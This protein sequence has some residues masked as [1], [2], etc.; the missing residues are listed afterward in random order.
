MSVLLF[1]T[2]IVRIGLASFSYYQ[3]IPHL[4]I[5]LASLLVTILAG[6]VV[7]KRFVRE[8]FLIPWYLFPLL[9]FIAYGFIQL[10]FRIDR[11]GIVDLLSY[12]SFVVLFL[13]FDKIK[14]EKKY[15]RVF[16]FIFFAL[17]VVQ[18]VAEL[19]AKNFDVFSENIARE[20]IGSI[21]SHANAASLVIAW[22]IILLL[23]KRGTAHL[24][25]RIALFLLLIILGTRSIIL[26]LVLLYSGYILSKRRKFSASP[27]I[28]CFLLLVLLFGMLLYQAHVVRYTQGDARMASLN[29]LKWRINHWGYYLA[30]LNSPAEILFGKGPGAHYPVPLP[31]YDQYREVHNDFLMQLFDFGLIGLLLF[32]FSELMIFRYFLKG[33]SQESK[34]IIY[35]IFFSK[36]FFLFFDNYATHFVENFIYIVILTQMRYFNDEELANSI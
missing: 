32:L 16:L 11:M 12:G 25:L 17:L 6:C 29:S 31:Y 13:Y 18:V 10:F 28:V 8:K 23:K 7:L 3:D 30:E 26:I 33:L 2:F 15:Y 24:I 34:I 5:Q 9:L 22:L 36:F 20:N 1:L 21:F 19:V 4:S 27:V 35:L 14:V